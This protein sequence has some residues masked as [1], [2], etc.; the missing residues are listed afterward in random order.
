ME[1]Q[2]P[3]EKFSNALSTLFAKMKKSPQIEVGDT[4]SYQ[5]DIWNEALFICLI[6]VLTIIFANLIRPRSKQTLMQ[7]TS[8]YEIQI[9]ILITKTDR[10]H[11]NICKKLGI[12]L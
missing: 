8:R 7:I 5:A 1:A 12:Q 10:L 11:L 2:K 6:V 3:I 9:Q 4:T